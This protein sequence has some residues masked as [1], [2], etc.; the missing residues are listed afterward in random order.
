MFNRY[1]SLFPG[2][3]SRV[4]TLEIHFHLVMRLRKTGCILLLSLCAWC[5]L[6]GQLYLKMLHDIFSPRW[7]RIFIITAVRTSNIALLVNTVRKTDAI[8]KITTSEGISIFGMTGYTTLVGPTTHQVLLLKIL[9][10]AP[11]IIT[12]CFS[13][14]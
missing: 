11:N 12:H 2:K 5:C 13:S 1:W 6:Q 14:I 3:S 10:K 8:R 9:L 7:T 4:V